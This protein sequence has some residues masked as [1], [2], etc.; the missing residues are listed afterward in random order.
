MRYRGFEIVSELC[1]TGD[2]SSDTDY[3][4]GRFFEYFCTVYAGNDDERLHPLE[5]FYAEFESYD[6][7]QDDNLLQG[8][9]ALR[10][11]DCYDDIIEAQRCQAAQRQ[12]ELLGRMVCWLSEDQCSAEL[13]N[14]LSEH[15]GMTDD[16][17][18]VVGFTSLV[19]F[20]DR[21][22]YAQT[23]AEHLIDEGTENTFSGNLHIPFSEINERFGVNLLTDKEMLELIRD[24]LL[25]HG[26]IISKL[27]ID[28]DFDMMFN[29]LYCPNMEHNRFFE[30]EDEKPHFIP[31]M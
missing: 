13:Y 30:D 12:L 19:P 7:A 4:N 8:E 22:A 14:T 9:I 26:D 23:I 29:T 21:E 6:E 16:E 5:E 27:K 20:F 18:R 1:D 11:D 24:E 17:I 31:Q 15:I 25:K 10:I 3:E 2:E 28:D